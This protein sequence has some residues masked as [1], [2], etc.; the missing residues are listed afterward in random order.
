MKETIKVY[1]YT[2][3]ATY[4]YKYK[5]ISS[6]EILKNC[7]VGI[8]NS[9]TDTI[10]IPNFSYILHP[11]WTPAYESITYED[12]Y[13]LIDYFTIDDIKGYESFI[14]HTLDVLARE[15]FKHKLELF[16]VK[17]DDFLYEKMV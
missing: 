6:S 13:I 15:N 14:N 5:N 1:H 3:I 17:G 10:T 4:N 8:Y 16:A 7:Y 12:D 2:Y 9:D 11:G